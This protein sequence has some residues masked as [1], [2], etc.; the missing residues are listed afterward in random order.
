MWT[1]DT[2]P[3]YHVPDGTGF[4]PRDVRVPSHAAGRAEGWDQVGVE[5]MRLGLRLWLR[6]DLICRV[7]WL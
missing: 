3:L 6:M 4:E 5:G 2:F 1:V 7:L